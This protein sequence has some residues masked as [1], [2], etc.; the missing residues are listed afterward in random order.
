MTSEFKKGL[1]AA[2]PTVFGYAS[3]GLAC[4]ILAAQSG[5]SPLEMAL[6]SLIVYSGSAQFALCGMV[7]AQVD[8]V[9]ATLTIFLLNLRN[10]LLNLHTTKVFQHYSLPKQVLAASMMTDE[11]YGI[12]LSHQL[13]VEEVDAAWM[14]GNN[15]AGYLSWLVF[16]V[17]GNLLGSLL[18]SP[19]KLGIDFALMVMFV[20]IFAGQLDALLKRVKLSRVALILA[21]VGGAYLLCSV[22]VQGSVA[23]LIATLIG[24][25]VGV[26]TDVD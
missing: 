24:C 17:L 26:M 19:E 22:L 11:S 1:Q 6:M 16:T 15:L 10:L 18:P 9:S 20:A 13:E 4:G 3:I 21:S 7:V 23:V 8:P 2:L 14:Y 12:L 5:I 25:L